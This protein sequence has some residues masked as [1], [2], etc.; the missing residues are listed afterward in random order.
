M[1]GE[2]ETKWIDGDESKIGND[3]SML[4]IIWR[5]YMAKHGKGDGVGDT[6]CEGYDV[7]GNCIVLMI[8]MLEYRWS[9]LL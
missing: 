7:A 3:D 9:G 5:S 1:I 2:G 6:K 4:V 8:N